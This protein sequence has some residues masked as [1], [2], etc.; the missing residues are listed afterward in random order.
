MANF[1][2]KHSTHADHSNSA[3]GLTWVRNTTANNLVV[4]DAG[5]NLPMKTCAGM[6][7]RDATTR[8]LIDSGTLTICSAPATPKE[9]PRFQKREVEKPDADKAE[10]PSDG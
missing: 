9:K 3:D 4:T 1:V 8:A 2:F 5:H 6:S 10:E 7:S